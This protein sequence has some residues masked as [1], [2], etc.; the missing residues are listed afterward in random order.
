MSRLRTASRASLAV[1]GILAMPLFFTALMAMSLAVEKPSVQHTGKLHKAVPG[2]PTGTTEAKIWL[3]A[4][5]FPLALVL[6]GTASMSLRRTGVVVTA[7]GA[8]ALTIALL[9]PLNGWARSHSARYP[10][11]VD[12]IPPS[13]GSQDIYL[14]GEWEANAKRT[15]EQLGIATMSIAGVAIVV[16]GLLEFRRR[17]GLVRPVPPPP[18]LAATGGV[19]PVT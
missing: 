8:I 11:G 18:P 16:A 6:I 3:L 2:D 1:A 19:P 9:V 5:V 7:L 12:L 15:A 17:R 10:V 13:A 4:L 14:R